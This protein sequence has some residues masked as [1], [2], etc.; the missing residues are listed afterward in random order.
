MCI[1]GIESEHENSKLRKSES[2]QVSSKN[3]KE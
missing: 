3:T 2:S 1:N